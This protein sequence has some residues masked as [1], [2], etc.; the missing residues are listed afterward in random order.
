MIVYARVRVARRG[1][2]STEEEHERSATFGV[3]RVDA[4]IAMS[5]IAVL[6]PA[7]PPA[8]ATDHQVVFD[9]LPNAQSQGSIARSSSTT[10]ASP[11][12]G[13]V[14]ENG[15]VRSLSGVT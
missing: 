2:R 13:L 12:R 14:D 8:E 4:F 6:T 15:D 7:S 5:A 9:P 3:G 11:S 1:R 10:T